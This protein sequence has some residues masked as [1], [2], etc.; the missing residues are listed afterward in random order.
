MIKLRISSGPTHFDGL[1]RQIACL[2]SESE[3]E[4]TLKKIRKDETSL[5]WNNNR[6]ERERERELKTEGK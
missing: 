5:V 2:T 3:I 1:R 6:T 4:G